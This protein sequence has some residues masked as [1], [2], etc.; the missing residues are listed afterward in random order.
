M[1]HKKLW[2]SQRSIRSTQLD[3]RW[4][5]YHMFLP[6][7]HRFTRPDQDKYEVTFL[8]SRLSTDQCSSMEFHISMVQNTITTVYH[9]DQ[10]YFLVSS[11]NT[12]QRSCMETHMP[13]VKHTFPTKYHSTGPSTYR[14]TRT[15]LVTSLIIDLLINPIPLSSTDRVTIQATYIATSQATT[16]STR[17]VISHHNIRRIIS[18]VIFP[19]MFLTAIQTLNRVTSQLTRQ[20]TAPVSKQMTSVIRATLRLTTNPVEIN[21]DNPPGRSLLRIRPPNSSRSGLVKL[22]PA[23]RL[24]TPTQGQRPL[25]RSNGS[26]MAR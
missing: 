12:G 2:Q 7:Y 20:A 1:C 23:N 4:S 15:S 17:P 26:T 9:Q 8:V 21:I 25:S 24:S 10:V 13:V 6:D 14:T 16:S 11:L 3:V 18:P 19:L 5:S 22:F